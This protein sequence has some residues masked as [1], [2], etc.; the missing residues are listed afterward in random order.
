MAFQTKSLIIMLLQKVIG[1]LKL[2]FAAKTKS[3]YKT[4]ARE[5]AAKYGI[6]PNVFVAVIMAE[7]GFNPLA[8]NINTDTST[9][10]G[11][12]QINDYW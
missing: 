5:Q 8:E 4:Y 7:S 9:D 2:V 6:D 1:L 12:V 11:I 3:Y 10:Y